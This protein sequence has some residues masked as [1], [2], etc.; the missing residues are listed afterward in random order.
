MSLLLA[1]QGMGLASS[2]TIPWG[3]R[4]SRARSSVAMMSSSSDAGG[5]QY[6]TPVG[7]FCPFRS[8]ATKLDGT[9][10]SGMGSLASK[11]Q[12]FMADMARLQLDSQM[13]TE[14]DPAKVEAVANEVAA[15]LEEWE[16]LMTRLRLSTDFQ[17]R[18]YFKLTEAH[19]SGQGQSLQ[20]IGLAMRWQVDA[21]RAFA[22]GQMPPMP[23]AGLDLEAM[24]RQ[25]EQGG[26]GGGGGMAGALGGPPAIDTTPFD[27]S[28]PAFESPVVKEEYEALCREHAALVSLGASYG[29]YDALGKLAFLDALDAVEGRWDIFFTRFSLVGALNADF[30]RQSDAFL[31]SMGLSPQSFRALL[32]KAHQIMRDEAEAERQ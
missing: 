22:K 19:L 24:S 4:S 11:S 14:P 32:G 18:E 13:G 23:P 26:G 2:L 31:Q 25:Q 15:A 17:S 9:V 8:E 1:L 28:E 20:A 16:L 12:S 29:S 3:V 10:D 27:G 30:K 7:P 5:P 6:I 21:M